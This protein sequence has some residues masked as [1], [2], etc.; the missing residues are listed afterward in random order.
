[1]EFKRT[2]AWHIYTEVNNVSRVVNDIKT[3]T[4]VYRLFH[5][6]IKHGVPAG[7]TIYEVNPIILC[8]LTQE[9]RK[10]FDWHWY[11]RLKDALMCL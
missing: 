4:G 6:N 9:C 5:S 1:M 8:D 2:I 7:W 10:I 11:N 3:R